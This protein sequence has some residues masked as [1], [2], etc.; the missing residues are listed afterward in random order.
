ME[1]YFH[2][3]LGIN[4]MSGYLRF[5]PYFVACFTHLKLIVW[6]LVSE[7]WVPN[8][9]QGRHWGLLN[10]SELGGWS[11]PPWD[12]HGLFKKTDIQHEIPVVMPKTPADL[13]FWMRSKPSP[14]GSPRWRS[15]LELDR[16][17]GDLQ[18]LE[19]WWENDRWYT[20]MAIQWP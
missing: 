10:P 7:N 5:A 17:W 6:P 18:P 13:P 8:S 9:W 1:N 19:N 15:E 14:T 20:V 11:S 16:V 12:P 2:I 4:S 3:P